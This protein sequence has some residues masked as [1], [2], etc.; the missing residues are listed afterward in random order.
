M[1][2]PPQQKQSVN[3]ITTKD[4]HQTLT[5]CKRLLKIH[6]RNFTSIEVSP[7]QIFF[8]KSPKGRKETTMIKS[9]GLHGHKINHTQ[10][11]YIQP[12]QKE[13]NPLQAMSPPKGKKM[14]QLGLTSMREESPRLLSSDYQSMTYQRLSLCYNVLR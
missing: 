7:I 8:L 13:K 3:D 11:G 6:R 12:P 10:L 14:H 2:A 4:H 9:Q 5:L 1:E